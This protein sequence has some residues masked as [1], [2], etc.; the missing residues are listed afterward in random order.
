MCDALFALVQQ[1][2]HPPNRV[3]AAAIGPNLNKSSVTERAGLA[4][5]VNGQGL[6]TARSLASQPRTKHAKSVSSPCLFSMACG[7]D[8][9]RITVVMNRAFRRARIAVVVLGL[10]GMAIGLPLRASDVA[11]WLVE[12][13]AEYT[14]TGSGRPTLNGTNGWGFRAD[15]VESPNG[16]VSGASLQPPGG[17]PVQALAQTASGKKWSYKHK[18][19]K[20]TALDRHFPNGAYTFMMFGRNDGTRSTRIQLL[21]SD[22]PSAPRIAN[23]PAVASV[24]PGGDF[25][26]SW[27]PFLGGTTNDYVQF[28]IEDAFGNKLFETPD[29]G[30]PGALN[31]LA[32][33]TVVPGGTLGLGQ[34]YSATLVFTKVVAADGGS[35]PGAQG[36]GGYFAATQFRLATTSAGNPPVLGLTRLPSG[37]FQLSIQTAPGLSYRLEGSSNLVQWLPLL[38]NSP[39]AGGLQWLDP[40]QRVR[41]FYRAAALP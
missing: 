39:A 32:P 30:K 16:A 5:S 9:T 15:V 13:G 23:F 40:T 25:Q 6:A 27:D 14:Q 7:D 37:S 18:Y 38:T 33:S 26:V 10:S 41:F 29:L 28:R 34:V 8:K 12:K 3:E 24:N 21:G 19:N 35:Y 20:L 36:F 22:Y 17:L 11:V 31:G 2:A 1:W 4:Q